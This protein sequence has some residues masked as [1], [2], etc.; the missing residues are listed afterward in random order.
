MGINEI[1]SWFVSL[2]SSVVQF[3]QIYQNY[4]MCNNFRDIAK[5][6]CG[7]PISL[8]LDYVWFVCFLVF[9]YVF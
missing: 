5:I 4:L 8:I 7:L 6:N 2:S 3:Y 1:G 9:V